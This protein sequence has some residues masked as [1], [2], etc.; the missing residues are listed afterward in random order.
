MDGLLPVLILL[1][2]LI[3]LDLLALRLGA[4]SRDRMPDTRARRAA[5]G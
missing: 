4:D 2:S 5:R 1:A 3:A